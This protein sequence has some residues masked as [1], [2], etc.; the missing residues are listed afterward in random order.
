MDTNYSQAKFDSV[1]EGLSDGIDQSSAIN[2][3]LRRDYV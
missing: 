3:E 2:N 1:V